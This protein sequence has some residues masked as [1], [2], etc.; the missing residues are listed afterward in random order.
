[1]YNQANEKQMDRYIISLLEKQLT[2]P[3][4]ETESAFQHSSNFIKDWWQMEDS[5]Y[6]L[7]TNNLKNDPYKRPQENY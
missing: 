6:I 2:F 1:M 4:Y 5:S 3:D 7:G